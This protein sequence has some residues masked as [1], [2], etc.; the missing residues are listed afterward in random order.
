M[1]A[2][3]APAP[4]PFIVGVGR[5]GTTLMR[6]MLD[7]HPELAI[8]PETHFLHRM[9][10]D[11]LKDPQSFVSSL[12]STHTWPDFHLSAEQLLAE[13]AALTSFD[14]SQA[15]RMFYRL[16]AKHQGKP[17][18]GD[19][20]PY[21]AECMD[22]IY[23]LLPEARFIHLIRD[24]RDVALSYRDKWF[25]PGQDL[26][27]AIEFWSGRILRARVQARLLPRHVVLELRYEDLVQAPEDAL[28]R[29]CQF[30]DLPFD[31]RMLTY[32]QTASERLAEIQDHHGL[33]G[34]LIVPRERHLAIHV[35]THRPPDPGQI[36]KW[37]TG[38]SPE[39]QT[40]FW[41]QAGS[42]LSELGYSP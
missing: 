41:Q 23:R 4:M 13:V 25:G 16:Y 2:P 3:A 29:V 37:R 20:T 31:S 24:G 18:W 39:E 1:I 40:F 27:G 34:E 28:K 10:I 36:E 21:N 14:L 19:K 38:L 7:A 30:I 42:L 15:I 22:H 26:A 32:F 9:H 12:K 6:L 11:Q 8:P 5:S 17:R 35:N 33:N